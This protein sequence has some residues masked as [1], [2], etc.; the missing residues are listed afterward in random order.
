M[1]ID[2]LYKIN[3]F[4]TLEINGQKHPKNAPYNVHGNR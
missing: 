4:Q 1:D 3:Y 2:K